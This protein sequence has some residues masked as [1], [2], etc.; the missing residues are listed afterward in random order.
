M[1]YTLLR[2]RMYRGKIPYRRRCLCLCACGRKFFAWAAHLRTGNTTSCGCA[3]NSRTKK[4][5][6]YYSEPYS[7]RKHPLNPL[8]T[9]WSSM[10]ERCTSPTHKHY[11]DY[12]GRGIR[13]CARWFSF[14]RFLADMGIPEKGLSLDRIN[15]DGNYEP[16]NCRWAT[17]K[18]Q[19]ANKRPRTKR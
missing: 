15:N 8:Y 4:R 5:A 18:Q 13:V 10:I 17:T 12:G 7:M 2:S 11:K 19:A 16:T 14:E 6:E 1:T 3:R 9:R